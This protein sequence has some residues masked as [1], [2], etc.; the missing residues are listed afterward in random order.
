MNRDP[1]DPSE[2]RPLHE[3]DGQ[4]GSSRRQFLSRL[5]ALSAGITAAAPL[6][7]SA[8]TI[9]GAAFE[10]QAPGQDQEGTLVE[11]SLKVNG[12][13]Q[14]LKVDPR[15][16]LYN[17]TGQRVRDFPITLDKLIIPTHSLARAP[18]DKL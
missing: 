5:A 17:A 4:P 1:N 13:P 6:A 10:G 15:V 9:E 11:I 16:T 7:R 3:A 8:T 12:R 18:A 2:A 14:K